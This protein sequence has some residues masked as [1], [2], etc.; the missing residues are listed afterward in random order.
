VQAQY[1]VT[2][3]QKFVDKNI[4]EIGAGGT[5]VAGLSALKIGAK[6][7]FTVLKF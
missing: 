3:R 1:I 4:I 5:G 6:C 7:V 2:N